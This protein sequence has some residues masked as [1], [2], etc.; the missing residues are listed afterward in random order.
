MSDDERK[1]LDESKHQQ[2]AFREHA[3]YDHRYDVAALAKLTGLGMNLIAVELPDL[4]W[5]AISPL[6]QAEAAAAF[7]ELTR[8]GRDKLLTGQTP[9][10]WPNAFR[11]ARFIPAV[12]YIQA[13]RA[14]ML[15]IE[16]MARLFSTVDVIVAPT[17]SPQLVATN[18]TGHPALILPSGFRGSD[19]PAFSAQ[20]GPASYGGPGTPVS[21]TFLG[22]LYGEAKLLAVARAYEQATAFHTQH[23]KL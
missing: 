18:L 11:A 12:E 22:Q 15:G 7:D 10:D 9:N 17:S 5:T 6:L 2:E 20:P 21:L 14:R 16:A 1:R 19:A 4:P 23:P 3:A 8:S 13:N